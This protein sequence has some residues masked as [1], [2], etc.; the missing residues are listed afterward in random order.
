MRNVTRRYFLNTT[1]AASTAAMFPLMNCSKSELS[2]KCTAITDEISPDLDH[3]LKVMQEFGMKHAELRGAWKENVANWSTEL[4]AK[5]KA[6]LQKHN[7]IPIALAS[8]LL[9]CTLPPEGEDKDMW[10]KEKRKLLNLVRVAHDLD[11]N[12]I[13]VFGFK[14]VTD[15][16]ADYSRIL[17]YL[18]ES[19]RIA[20]ENGCQL[21]FENVGGTNFC[22]TEETLPLFNDITS[23]A[24]G[25][26]WDPGN[27]LRCGGSPYPEAYANMPKNRIVHVHLKDVIFD[28]GGNGRWAA[29]G[30][31]QLDITG[32][33]RALKK[34]GYQGFL[35][36]ETH[37]KPE[38]GTKEDGTRASW[39]GL[40]KILTNL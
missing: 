9:K 31:G 13:R 36:L 35:S 40:Q 2:F 8:P 32:I 17:H 4:T 6:S 5:V 21:I 19:V 37:Y 10:E 22:T 14:P 29:I 1:I 38:G 28:D 25:W 23:P 24:F 27:D 12:M 18:S 15:L 7:M 16:Q 3:A 34:D 30:D 39:K 11:V 26:L 20:A 33:C